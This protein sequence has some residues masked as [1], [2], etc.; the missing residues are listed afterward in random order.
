MQAREYPTPRF[1]IYKN[2]GRPPG[3]FGAEPETLGIKMARD[4]SSSGSLDVNGFDIDVPTKK[5]GVI[6]TVSSDSDSEQD[7]RENL[8]R[9]ERLFGTDEDA[10]QQPT[11]TKRELWAYYLYYNGR[12]WRLIT[13]DGC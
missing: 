7:I 1:A 2:I 4:A 12:W 10:I 8:D 9:Y 11:T 6:G 13:P 3:L 5:P